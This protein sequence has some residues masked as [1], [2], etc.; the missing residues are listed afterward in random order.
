MPH[1]GGQKREFGVDIRMLAIP[2][3]EAVDGEGSAEFVQMRRAMRAVAIRDSQAVDSQMLH[4]FSKILAGVGRR[5]RPASGHGKEE[6][7]F[8][9]NAEQAL[10]QF[11][12][13]FKI[14]CG[15]AAYRYQTILME[16]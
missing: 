11:E 9:R 8:W 10:A 2:P 7:T 4:R 12:E 3:H 5:I 1:V 14:G 13:R 15:A 16:L 6:R